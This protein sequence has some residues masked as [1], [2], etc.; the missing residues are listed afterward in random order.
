MLAFAGLVASQ[1]TDANFVAATSDLDKFYNKFCQGKV[2]EIVTV[3]ADGSSTT[4]YETH[5]QPW[6]FLLGYALG[7]QVYADDETSTCYGQVH[8]TYKFIDVIAEQT[9]SIMND[10][11]MNT[12]SSQF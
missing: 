7:T 10:F 1:T 4:T 8:E 12:V 11:S 2:H 9:Y 5:F 3:A 6:E